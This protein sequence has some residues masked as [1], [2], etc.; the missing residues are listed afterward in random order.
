MLM[1]WVPT[2]ARMAG[3][4]QKTKTYDMHANRFSL[5]SAPISEK[6]MQRD[7]VTGKAAT[8]PT[9]MAGATV[10]PKNWHHDI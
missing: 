4:Y 2:H 8:A 6:V 7:F 9:W 3:K 10:S 5:E 1:G